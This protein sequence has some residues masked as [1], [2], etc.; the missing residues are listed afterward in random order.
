MLLHASAHH[1]K[2]TRTNVAVFTRQQRSRRAKVSTM[3]TAQPYKL[4]T[5]GTPNGWKASVTLEELGVP[6]EVKPISLSK[7]EQKED[8]FLK[9]NPNGRIPAML[10]GD[11]RVFESG[12][13]MLYLVQKHPETGLYS[14][15]PAEQ[16]EILSWLMFQ[17]G[18]LGPMQGQ[19]NHFVRYAPEQIPY[20]INRYTNETK[21]LYNVLESGLEGRD[22]LAGPGKGKYTIA[23]IANF[24]WVY[25]HAWAGIPLDNLP[26]VQAW[27]KRIEERPAVQK[28][29]NVPEPNKFKE[30]ADPEK[31]KKMVEEARKMMA[32]RSS[33]LTSMI[34][35]T[36]WEEDGGD[37]IREGEAKSAKAQNLKELFKRAD[38]DGNGVIDRAELKALLQSTDSGLQP[39]TLD[40][41]KD[42][43]VRETLQKYDWDGSGDIDLREFEGLVE[44]GLLM[45]GKLEEYQRAWQAAGGSDLTGAAL[46]QLFERL[47]QPLD[48]EQLAV[49]RE[50]FDV[51][52]RDH[53]VTFSEFLAMFRAELL[54]LREIM[55]F[56]RMGS[57][58]ALPPGGVAA[59][60]WQP[61]EVSL[62]ESE[63]EFDAALVQ[64]PQRLIV[65]EASLTWCRP[66]KGF[67]R[68]Y[69]KFAAHYA[70]CVF[71]KFFGNANEN[72]KYLFRD[73][74]QTP[75]TPTFSFW[76]RG[77]KLHQH[78]GANN[79]KMEAVLQQLVSP[80]EDPS[81]GSVFKR[82]LWHAKLGLT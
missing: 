11:V 13:I 78:C 37:D 79:A 29:L 52:G 34:T 70:S 72:T 46:E 4:L 8:W 49:L 36:E 67:E 71:I 32:G 15:D 18:G 64:H 33:D 12:A 3:A 48:A 17:M 16:A 61:G 80:E 24:C 42:S 54:D 77:Q 40:W 23:D 43:E 39:V 20:G 68:S 76:R 57:S 81:F 60:E 58:A 7:I 22:Y 2:Q 14:Q 35:M 28:G 50:R 62:L 65:L 19:A 26:N 63:E 53:R 82:Q 21:R 66:C 10:D 27:K 47:G 31:E 51:A 45:E 6:Y 9:V 30:A 41:M 73:R 55:G 38:L 44:D 69:Q 74:L 59:F 5:A 25:C 75:L 1:V 56:L